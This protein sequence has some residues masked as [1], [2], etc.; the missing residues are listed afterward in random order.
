MKNVQLLVGCLLLVAGAVVTACGTG[1]KACAVVD[2]SKV[3]CDGG[4]RYLAKD[5]TPELVTVDDLEAVHRQK[6]AARAASSAR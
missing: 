5:G 4:L 3:I 1:A 6:A 2:A